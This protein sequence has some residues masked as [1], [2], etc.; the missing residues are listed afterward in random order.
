MT[1]PV[2]T[3]GQ[4]APMTM[5][6]AWLAD[7]H[8]KDQETIADNL[9][10]AL[11]PLW[12]IMRF[13]NL[14]ASSERF[15]SAV[16]PWIETA[17]LQSQRVSSVYVANARYAEVTVELPLLIDYP[18]VQRPS[19][20]SLDSFR[21]PQ[22]AVTDF[23]FNP[24]VDLNPV[25]PVG[26][27]PVELVLDAQSQRIADQIARG[28]AMGTPQFVLDRMQELDDLRTGRLRQVS[29]PLQGFDRVDVAKTVMIESNYMTK[30]AMPGPEE[31]IMRDASVR[32]AGAAVRES[33][34]GARG[35]TN[36]VMA[37]DKRIKGFAR[38]TD[39]DPCPLCALLA[40][41]GAVFGKGSFIG[42][43]KRFKASPDVERTV[44]EGWYDIAK[45]HDNCR[46][47][48]R[49]VYTTKGAQDAAA[50]YWNN[51]WRDKVWQKVDKSLSGKARKR[52]EMTLWREVFAETKAF[53]GNQFD[54]ALMNGE[55]RDAGET[56]LNSGLSPRDPRVRWTFDMRKQLAA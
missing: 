31:K 19:G 51:L 6:S 43:N 38:V 42:S 49:P 52:A 39:G 14:D 34:N 4:I 53:D 40:A 16:L 7:R 30:R 11:F 2:T 56:L 23:E 18:D 50:L 5:L 35:V 46:C 10:L 44:P 32:V 28:A 20:V 13:R 17:F 55:L 21:M 25:A 8:A 36:S 47:M 12:Q 37:R 33:M 54:M 9:V 45:V 3:E 27:S 41:R 24:V 1:A 29:V 15:T 48:L 22:L 26:V